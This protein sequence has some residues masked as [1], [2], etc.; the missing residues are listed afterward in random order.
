ME[1]NILS[2]GK[3]TLL[4]IRGQVLE[5]DGCKSRVDELTGEEEKLERA[6]AIREKQIAEEIAETVRKRNAEVASAFDQEEEK[7]RDRLKKVK[8]KKERFKNGKMSERIEVETAGLSAEN[9]QLKQEAKSAFRQ[10]HAPA[11][12]NT[13]LYYGLFMPKGPGD[14][15]IC[16]V[17][18]LLLFA[19]VPVGVYY[20]IPNPRTWYWALIYIGAILLFGGI[21]VLIHNHTKGKHG[22]VLVK[23]RRIRSKIRQNRKVMAKIRRQIEKDKDESVYG[24]EQFDQEIAA[25]QQEQTDLAARRKDAL[26]YFENTTRLAIMDEIRTR[27]QADLDRLKEQHEETYRELKETQDKVKQKSLYVAENYEAFLGREF[28]SAT[29]LDQMLE[30]MEQNK[31]ATVGEALALY[32]TDGAV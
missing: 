11:V 31:A 32:K 10:A 7:L 3:D 2:A 14:L 13:G 23:G 6:V 16:L 27:N 4:E 29:V 5:L 17:T 12:L 20:L 9:K 24:L 22:E 1:Q 26:A 30:L 25:V 8:T 21:Y 18:F 19:A 15:L 28:V